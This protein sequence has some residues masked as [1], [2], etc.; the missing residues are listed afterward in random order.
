MKET[1]PEAFIEYSRFLAA[2][3]ALEA[4]KAE[5]RVAKTEW[6]SVGK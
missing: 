6:D 4:A 1:L 5:Y 3:Q 2:E